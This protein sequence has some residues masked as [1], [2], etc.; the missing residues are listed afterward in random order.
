[1]RPALPARRARLLPL[2]LAMLATLAAPAAQAQ[3]NDELLRELRALRDRV[4]ELERRLQAQ[5][6]AAPAPGQWG[7]T[8]EQARELARL[9]VKAESLQDNFIDQGFKGLRISGQIDPSWI[10][11][12][13]SDEAGF[14]LLNGGGR[15]TY[16][17]SYFGM[18]VLDLQKETDSGTLWR[19]TLA[20][21]R[22]TGAVLTGGTSIVH[23]ASVSI[24]LGD[25]NTRLWLGQIPD[26]TGY[27]ITLPAGNK[28][29]THNLLFDL[30]APT[31]YT[32]AVLDLT[33]G[34][35]WSRIGLANVNAARSAPGQRTPALVYRVDYARGEFGGFGFT[36]LHGRLP[37]FAADNLYLA[38]P[39]DPAS[40]TPFAS[41][42][43]ATSAHL[44]EFDAYFIRGDWS[45]F[46]Q[47]SHGRQR[48][49]AIF[50]SDG[51]LR[52]ASW[53]GVSTTVG[54]KITPRLEAVARA[55]YIRN[56]RN[57]G[58]LLGYSFDDPFNGIGRGLLA[59]GSTARGDDVGANRWAL[60]LGGNY[61]L[62]ENTI[63][64]LEYRHDGAS[65]PV[66]LRVRQGTMVKS[67]QLLGASVV[68]SF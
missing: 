58:G 35:W 55:D 12:R 2:T 50:N 33:R 18:A 21:E 15:Y 5:P 22:G 10:F 52:D 11:N 53:T 28:L 67:N 62:D 37:N 34:K 23:E 60:S 49:A 19:L 66:F 32:G 63:V 25:N 30:T 29:V 41:A 44:L 68:V 43:K 13:N 26:W 61:L 40:L 38:D 46:G 65:Q 17:N 24:P 42:G 1:M 4:A 57:G 6:P 59:D 51:V 64:K 27:E 36:G 9:S 8:P 3:S 20:P 48:G 39:A 16:D 56:T 14:V 47:I 45:L 7:M 54:Y 31:A